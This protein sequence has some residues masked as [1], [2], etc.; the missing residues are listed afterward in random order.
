MLTLKSLYIGAKDK[1]YPEYWE[2]DCPLSVKMNHQYVNK[3]WKKYQ[4]DHLKEI[5]KA[6]KISI[7]SSFELGNVISFNIL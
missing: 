4:K 2:F 5:L 7:Y 3:Q 1:S 6:F